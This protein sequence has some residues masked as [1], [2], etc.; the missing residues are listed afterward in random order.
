MLERKKITL[1]SEINKFISSI[2]VEIFITVGP[3]QWHFSLAWE[4]N[5]QK[6]TTFFPYKKERKQ[7]VLRSLVVLNLKYQFLFNKYNIINS[8]N[9]TLTFVAKLTPVFSRFGF[10]YNRMFRLK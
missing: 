3:T 8:Y 6:C 9:K 5:K 7:F 1:S 4:N 2:P 10:G